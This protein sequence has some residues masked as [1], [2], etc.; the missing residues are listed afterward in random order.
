MNTIKL[1]KGLALTLLIL[2]VIIIAVPQNVY[3]TPSG[4]KIVG[5]NCGLIIKAS[6]KKEDTSNLNPGDIKQTKLTLINGGNNRIE[7]V[8]IKTNIIANSELSPRGGNLADIL[9]LTIKDGN[10]TIID[11]LSFRN[12]AKISSKSLGPM[13][14]GEEKVLDFIINFPSSADNDYQG[15]SFQTNWTFT[16]TCTGSSSGGDTGGGGGR[17]DDPEDSDQPEEPGGDISVP[18]EDIPAGPID[19]EEPSV[20][21]IEITVDDEAIPI[22]PTEMPKTGEMAPIYF[23]GFGAFI[24]AIGIYL[25]FK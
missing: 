2:C 15:A 11:D 20:P 16:T 3:A 7:Q 13:D 6:D 21:D 5:D 10:N 22:G 24:V 4:I 18:D 17:S 1:C 9:K 25:R 19:E 12:A 23:I 8:Y 14:A